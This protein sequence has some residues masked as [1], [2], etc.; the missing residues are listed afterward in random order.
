MR[1]RLW[2]AA[3][4][5]AACACQRAPDSPRAARHVVLVTIDTLRADRLGCYG[6]DV[7]TPNLDRIASEGALAVQA[8]AHAP[9][10]RPSHVS[11]FTGRL[12][13][14]HGIRDNVSPAVVPDT[15][16]LAEAFKKAGFATAA[17]V[18]SVV[19]ASESGLDR[20][21][22]TYSDHFEGARG[23][24][25]FLNTV[26]KRGDVTLAEATA[27]LE[28][29]HA[30]R[31]FA[32]IHL[33]DPH[34]PYEPP[35]P[36]AS[37]YAGRPYD[38]EV[39]WSDE[40]IGRLDAALSRLGIGKE[41]LLLV[42][43]DHGEGLG[44]HD[45]ALHGFFAYQTTLR[46]PLIVRGP[47]I[48]PG[49]RLATTAMLVDVFPTVLELAGLA[50]P[51]GTIAGRS[52]AAALR[53]GPA[54]TEPAAYAETLVPLL[55]F[56]WSDLRV[57]REGRFKYIQAPRPELYDLESDPGERTNLVD[58]EPRRAEA[59]RG[60]LGRFLDLERAQARGGPAQTVSTELI[61]KLGALGYVGGG[62]AATTRTPGADPKDKIE[63]FRI[64][65]SLI[66]EGL[67]ASHA[68]QHEESAR[69][70]R[71]VLARGVESFEVHYYLARALLASGRP[72]EAAPHFRAAVERQP[73]HA[74]AWEGLADCR[75]RL[76]DARGAL[77]A[78]R[79]GQQALPGDAGLRFREARTLKTLGD[80][81]GA[82]KAY[83]AALALAPK[84][85]RIHVELGELLRDMGVPDE[86]IRRLRTG[87]ELQPSAASY[88][89][90]LGM[91]L[92]AHAEAAEAEKAFREAV[93]LDGASARYAYN[94]GL[95][96]QRQ[97]RA[98][99]ARPFF[100]QA[101]RLDPGFAPA[102]ERIAELGARR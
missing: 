20:G 78:L 82:R 3:A 6:S 7:K 86:A 69:R 23:D 22:D 92:G 49:L 100:E 34:D 43:S 5:L 75:A 99:E 87:V 53:G 18:S 2:A 70:L 88:W 84:D 94:L 12:P 52:L 55:H 8:T 14:E 46:V 50:A 68:G 95:I 37:R 63:E 67:L 81:P 36:F 40:L 66:R 76:R 80:V 48:G 26:Q 59:M 39:A 9:L 31:L 24:A 1:A 35:E 57:V 98:A 97:G 65:N 60:A 16:L 45:E 73:S 56:G 11:L 47:T 71:A 30:R 44:E 10:T 17:F 74:A 29:N 38:G 28:A 90:S 72:S 58:R 85:A 61:E 89:N 91:V 79:E 41:T 77:A 54:P 27:W 102:R 32:W 51:P 19:L 96:L 42:A 62:G 21:F 93:R 83:E 4:A 15:P 64:V 33:Y 13:F 101:L 25:Q